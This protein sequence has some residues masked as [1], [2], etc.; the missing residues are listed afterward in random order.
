MASKSF[1]ARLIQAIARPS[2]SPLARPVVHKTSIARPAFVPARFF[3]HTP[4][5]LGQRQ[6]KGRSE[7]DT[8]VKRAHCL[9]S[10]L[11]SAKHTARSDGRNVQSAL[12]A[13]SLD[14][15]VGIATGKVPDHG[16]A[17]NHKTVASGAQSALA[18]MITK[19]Q[20]RATIKTL[21][22]KNTVS[23]K[24]SMHRSTSQP[25]PKTTFSTAS[26]KSRP[27]AAMSRILP[28][29]ML[30]IQKLLQH[31]ARW[32]ASLRRLASRK[33]SRSTTTP[34]TTYERSQM[35]KSKTQ[36]ASRPPWPDI[37][38]FTTF[39][40]AKYLL[41]ACR[42]PLST[43][44]SNKLPTVPPRQLSGA[45]PRPWPLSPYS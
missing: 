31:I 26:P 42:A 22:P 2:V 32:T 37:S 1:A 11:L 43:F 44:R 45:L 20:E 7:P 28:Q 36:T 30:A 5:A 12:P 23:Q 15:Y 34:F 39:P 16:L 17:M 13:F 29:W 14:G 40:A 10:K 6:H 19:H 41:E 9:K 24:T 33:A 4:A 35:V 25:L 21:I 3:R 38:S 27:M 8:Q 18:N